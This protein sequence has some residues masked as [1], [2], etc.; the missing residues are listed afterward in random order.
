MLSWGLTCWMASLR[1]VL[2]TSPVL[3]TPPSQSLSS[4]LFLLPWPNLC[5][6]NKASPK[7]GM[8]AVHFFSL[9]VCRSVFLCPLES[10]LMD[11]LT[12]EKLLGC[13]E[14]YRRSQAEGID[15]PISTKTWVWPPG[16]KVHVYNPSTEAVVGPGAHLLTHVYTYTKKKK[17]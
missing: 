16:Q 15:H 6:W 4:R 10:H 17:L 12:S 13:V 9:W 1:D 3:E 8:H 7:T 5:W 11:N 14:T 2:H